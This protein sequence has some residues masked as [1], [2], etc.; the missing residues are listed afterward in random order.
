MTLRFSRRGLLSAAA[1]AV[2]G[3]AS[4]H[5]SRPALAAEKMIRIG[6]QKYGT[7]ILL[8]GKGSSKRRS[9]PWAMA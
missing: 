9:S 4:H 7:L 8:K 5:V 2:L 3:A 6:Y 1:G